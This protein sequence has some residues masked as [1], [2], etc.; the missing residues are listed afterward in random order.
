ML[1]RQF[2]YGEIEFLAPGKTLLASGLPQ[3]LRRAQLILAHEFQPASNQ[4]RGVP[5]G[6]LN[7]CQIHRPQVSR[8]QQAHAYQHQSDNGADQRDYPT[9]HFQ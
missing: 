8:N 1:A 5:A 2:L 4:A 3:Q 9:T 7:D 6:F